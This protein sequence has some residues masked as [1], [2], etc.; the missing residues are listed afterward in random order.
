VKPVCKFD[1]NHPDILCH[2]EEH[3]AQILSLYFKLILGVTELSQLRD[4]VHEESNFL[5]EFFR[6]IIQRHC[7]IFHCVMQHARNNRFLIHLKIRKD[8]SHP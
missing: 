8:N 7:S 6:N 4:A 5:A 2:G 3:L 1:N